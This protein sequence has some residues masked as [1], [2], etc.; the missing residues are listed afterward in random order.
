M[1][2]FRGRE[3]TRREG[4]VRRRAIWSGFGLWVFFRARDGVR[5]WE[6]G[7]VRDQAVEP[8]RKGVD[9]LFERT[10]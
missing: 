3:E 6:R 4:F 1:R 5:G 7:A 10:R 9:E 2:G 8:R